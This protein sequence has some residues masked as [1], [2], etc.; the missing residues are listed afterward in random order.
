[1]TPRNPPASNEVALTRHERTQRYTADRERTASWWVGGLGRTTLRSSC[2]IRAG[3]SPRPA[4]G[5]RWG[6]KPGVPIRVVHVKSQK[7]VLE[8][9]V[10]GKGQ[11]VTIPADGLAGQ[12]AI[13]I[14]GERTPIVEFP[15]SD[16]PGEVMSWKDVQS[17]RMQA[18]FFRI[19]PEATE[20]EL[21]V[22][23]GYDASCGSVC[24][25]DGRI[26]ARV[27]DERMW[28]MDLFRI[29]L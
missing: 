8:T 18:L 20:V 28:G 5:R 3:R 9:N 26:I 11:T 23:F 15:V 7:L 12:Y 14:A 29:T 27:F 13:W 16:L 19:L 2:H 4:T 10:S 22:A 6:D 17:K 21:D 1:M 24:Q 25:T